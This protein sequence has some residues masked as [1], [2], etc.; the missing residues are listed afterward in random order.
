MIYSF[1]CIIC[2]LGCVIEIEMENGKIKEVRG[3]KCPRGKEWAIE[4]L[5]SPKRIV[6]TVLPVE[7]SELPVVSVKTSQPVDVRKI[8][9]LM[10]YL[11]ELKL[12]A[13]IKIGDVVA[14][15]RGVKIIATREAKKVK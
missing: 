14:E 11:S 13:P 3:N 2:P 12:M 9:S 1:T 5:L 8:P 4:E 7:K 6:I 15:F 10:K